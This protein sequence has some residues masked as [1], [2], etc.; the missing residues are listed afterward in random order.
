MF[1][2]QLWIAWLRGAYDTYGYLIVLLGTLGEN[3]AFLGAILP[4][5]T[6]ALLGAFSACL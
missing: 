2:I 3:T 5:G 4:G 1:N 6:L